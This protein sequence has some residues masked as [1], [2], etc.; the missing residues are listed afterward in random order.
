MFLSRLIGKLGGLRED[1]AIEVFRE[2]RENVFH[3]VE[4]AVAIED[5][6]DDSQ[7]G[8]FSVDVGHSGCDGFALAG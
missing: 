2:K 3:N 6:L 5:P 1:L 7:L 4:G 8:S